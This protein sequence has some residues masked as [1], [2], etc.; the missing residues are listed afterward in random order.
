MYAIIFIMKSQVLICIF[1]TLFSFSACAGPHRY[2]RMHPRPEDVPK[3]R[4]FNSPLP[5]A[6]VVCEYGPRGRDFHEGIDLIK[7]SRGGDPVHAARSGVVIYA[8]RKDGYGRMVLIR[9]RDGSLTR[10]AHLKKIYVKAGQ[11]VL[12][13]T[14]IGLVGQSGKATG[15]H[16]HY[17]VITRTGIPINPHPYLR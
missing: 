11:K 2:L 5:G 9:H 6:V 3:P 10:Y 12:A 14:V 8:K 7:S 15:P 13:G 17:E 1:A 4:A 16:L